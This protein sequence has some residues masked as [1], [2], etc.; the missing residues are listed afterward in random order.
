[1][2]S[3]S[4]L[5]A[6]ALMQVDPS[7]RRTVVLV[8]VT[9]DGKSSTGNTISGR[10]AFEVSGGFRSVT[11]E[12]E[13]AD[14][15]ADGVATRVVDTIG[16]HDTSLSA[17]DVIGR[18]RRFSEHV[19]LGI[20]CFIF[21]VRWGR[22]K[23]ENEAALEAFARNCGED[24][25]RH[26]LLCF[27]SC[28]LDD[29]ALQHALVHKAPPSLLAW[30]A[31]TAG[32]IGIDNR[33]AAAEGRAALHA[34][35]GRVCGANEGRYSNEALEEA[36]ANHQAAEEEERAAFTGAVADWRKGSGPVAIEREFEAAP[37]ADDAS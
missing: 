16:L 27:T 30:V 33:D 24:A 4:L 17:V 12:C 14:Y 36:K 1:M 3:N 8:G 7:E 15:M 13:S 5:E 9:G 22:F 20:D 21:V 10:S 34:A 31:R 11:Q 28:E 37:A 35:I 25:L 19:P 18:F 6:L 29:A 32:A 2:T 26:T 23:P